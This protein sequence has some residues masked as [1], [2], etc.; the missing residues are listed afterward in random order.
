VET[1]VDYRGNVDLGA[2]ATLD[3]GRISRSL[4]RVALLK[5]RVRRSLSSNG[6]GTAKS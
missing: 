6:F 3:R 5:P 2:L 1:S 4:L